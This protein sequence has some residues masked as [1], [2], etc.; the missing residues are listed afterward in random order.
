MADDVLTNKAEIIER[1]VARAR[2]KYQRDPVSFEYNITRQDAAILNIQR[3]CQAAPDMGQHL[4]WRHKLGV[5]KNAHDVFVL[6][7]EN[8]WIDEGLVGELRQMAEFRGAAIHNYQTLEPVTVIATINH[9]LDYLLQ[10]AQ[11]ILLN[12]S[13]NK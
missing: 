1:C 2:E 9:H 12:N 8:G 13:K 10:Y 3:A 4:I 6:L 11:A 7:G 5:P